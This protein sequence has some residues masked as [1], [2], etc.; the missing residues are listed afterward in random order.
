MPSTLIKHLEYDPQARVLS[1]ELLPTG[2]LYRY[3]DVPPATY[4]AF[5]SAFAKGRFFN[6]FI[7]GRFAFQVC[8][9]IV[10]RR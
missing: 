6:R 8:Q 5:R 3:F 9:G 10:A 2:V 7:R 1:V 4:E